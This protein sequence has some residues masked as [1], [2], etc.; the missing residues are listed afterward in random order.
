MKHRKRDT[1][2]L[3]GV[4]MMSA[5]V[6]LLANTPLGLINIPPIKATTVHIPVIL[7]AVLLGPMMLENDL[8]PGFRIDL[9]I[10][11]LGNALEAGHKFGSPLPLTAQVMEMLQVLRADGLG[12][13]DHSAIAKFYEKVTGETIY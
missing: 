8:R 12:Q 9:H 1:R 5:I 4:A 3:V 7:G 11:D 13:C 6:V 2:W 10:K